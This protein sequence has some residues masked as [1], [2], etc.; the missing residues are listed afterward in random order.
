MSG[1]RVKSG[2]PRLKNLEAIYLKKFG[3][4]N[5]QMNMK[6]QKG[7]ASTVT[8]KMPPKAVRVNNFR[9]NEFTVDGSYR[10]ANQQQVAN[11]IDHMEQQY[12][13]NNQST[14]VEQFGDDQDPRLMNKSDNYLGAHFQE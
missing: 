11:E 8:H 3:H 4:S 12:L 14:R 5:S 10:E 2:D 9:T 6:F 13:K 1:A 7:L